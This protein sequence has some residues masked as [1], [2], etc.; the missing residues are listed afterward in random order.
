LKTYNIIIS[1]TI[2]VD[3]FSPS[4]ILQIQELLKKN[5]NI[6]LPN[7]NILDFTPTGIQLEQIKDLKYT[8]EKLVYITCKNYFLLSSPIFKIKNINTLYKNVL[9][10]RDINKNEL[11][12]QRI[13]IYSLSDL[14]NSATIIQ[15]KEILKILKINSDTFCRSV[16]WIY[17]N[18]YNVPDWYA[19]IFEINKT[20]LNL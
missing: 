11:H 2:K 10:N 14:Y 13:A 20:F 19:K 4:A 1:G 8:I 6:N 17:H 5:I 3:D 15:K 16:K 7:T 18:R 12:A 9:R